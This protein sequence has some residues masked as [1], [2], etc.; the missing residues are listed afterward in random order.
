MLNHIRKIEP[1]P[2]LEIMSG[3]A[4]PGTVVLIRS[5]DRVVTAMTRGIDFRLKG[6]RVIDN[7][8]GLN[9]AFS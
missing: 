9:V 5:H 3:N 7:G 1:Q 8:P 2:L 6:Y 4:L